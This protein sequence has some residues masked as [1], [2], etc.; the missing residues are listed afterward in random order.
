MHLRTARRYGRPAFQATASWLAIAAVTFV[1]YGL[2]LNA[3]TV[4]LLYLLVIVC[5]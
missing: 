4:V 3:A 2:H 5:P 1:S